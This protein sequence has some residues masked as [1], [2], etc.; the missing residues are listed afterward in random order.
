[1]LKLKKNALFAIHNTRIRWVF[2]AI[3]ASLQKRL[4]ALCSTWGAHGGQG[5]FSA[6]HNDNPS[7]VGFQLANF[8][9]GGNFHLWKMKTMQK[10]RKAV[11]PH[12][13]LSNTSI[14]LLRLAANVNIT[15]ILTGTAA[16]GPSPDPIRRRTDKQWHAQL[17]IPL[18]LFHTVTLQP[19]I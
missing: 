8:Q 16:L 19:Q 11:I 10:C 17:F 3:C 5:S 14:T 2:S 7:A 12:R 18:E 13:C 1:M 9:Q 15:P 4:Q 6:N